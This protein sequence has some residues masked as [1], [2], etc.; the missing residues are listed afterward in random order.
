MQKA[1]VVGSGPAG[2]GAALA[3]AREGIEVQVLEKQ[4]KPGVQRRGETI[5]YNERMESL[6]G[7]GFFQKQ[8]IHKVNK[9][10]YYSHTCKKY[11][12]R[13]ISTYNLII[14]WPRWIE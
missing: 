10:R 2:I 14:A 11:V 7:P 1:I 13:K 3:L 8:T 5:R 4:Q 6:L 9:R 12:D